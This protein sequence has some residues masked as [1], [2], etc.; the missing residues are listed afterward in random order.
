MPQRMSVTP[1]AIHKRDHDPFTTGNRRARMVGSS[2]AGIVNRRPF[3]RPISIVLSF[4][5]RGDEATS[6]DA[7]AGGE[8]ASGTKPVIAE[9]PRRPLRYS[10]RQRVNND[11]DNPYR[12]AATEPCRKPCR[13][14][15]TIRTF[16]SSDQSTNP[17][18]DQ[19]RRRAKPQWG[20]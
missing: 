11:R 14:S 8:T 20:K 18:G 6:Q 9:L 13:L 1:P 7:A 15:P 10:R 5:N 4:S 17:V 3:G 19:D 12:R 16:S 2:E